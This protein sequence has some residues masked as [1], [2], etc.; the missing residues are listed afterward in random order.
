MARSDL[1][2][3]QGRGPVVLQGGPVVLLE[4]PSPQ[5]GV[6]EA[7]ERQEMQLLAVRLQNPRRSRPQ[8]TMSE[9]GELVGQ[10]E[11]VLP[12]PSMV[13]SQ[14]GSLAD[15]VATPEWPG[16]KRMPVKKPSQPPSS[17]PP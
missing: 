4:L 9:N 13:C 15:L 6:V 16:G 12:L 8:Q 1:G 11:G 14:R 2:A 7:A 17:A 10:V 3:P 5:V